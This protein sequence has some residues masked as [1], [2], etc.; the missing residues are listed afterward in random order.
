MTNN[1][2]TRD[3]LIDILTPISES[4]DIWLALLY[5][6]SNNDL[7]PE[8]LDSL[9]TIVNTSILNAIKESEKDV[10][11][12]LK[13]KLDAIKLAEAQQKADEP[14]PDLQLRSTRP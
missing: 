6:V 9:R 3:Y 14:D 12:W 7:S 2:S 5:I 1:Q 4:S 10:L 13:N 8:L 11:V